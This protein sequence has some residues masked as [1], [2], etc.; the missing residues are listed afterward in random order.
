MATNLNKIELQPGNS[1]PLISYTKF[2]FFLLVYAL[3]IILWGA[4][5]RISGSG[6]GCGPHWP[7]CQGQI[8][9][10]QSFTEQAKTL[11]EL[12][13]R[14]KSGLFGILVLIQFFW[15][16]KIFPINHS[17]RIAAGLTLILTITEALL[18]AKLVL[19][20]L[21]ADNSSG[22]RA[23]SMSLHLGNT[24]LLL[25]AMTACW[26]SK[27]LLELKPFPWPKGKI[28]IAQICL[29]II[30]IAGSWAALAST[31]FPSESLL[32]GLSADFSSNSHWLLRIRILHPILGLSL[33]FIAIYF[34]QQIKEELSQSRDRSLIKIT[35]LFI[36][37][38]ILVGLTTLLSGSPTWLKLTH[39]LSIDLTWICLAKLSLSRSYNT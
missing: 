2:S 26:Q 20:G 6:D 1:Q 10:D 31:L 5:V 29:L 4:W 12:A 35:Q 19:L 36:L 33:S 28:L 16:R 30:A 24:L 8:L 3:L 7:L 32:L 11:I 27:N 13:H 14:L 22:L 34:L 17:A 9:I 23:F 21:V 25:Y 18:G 37:L 15:A 39:L 38:P